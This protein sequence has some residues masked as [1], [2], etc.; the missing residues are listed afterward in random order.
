[1]AD[2]WENMADI[3][4][5]SVQC[6]G[7]QWS[8]SST[9]PCRR[10]RSGV[11]SVSRHVVKGPRSSEWYYYDSLVCP[12]PSSSAIRLKKAL[13]GIW[14]RRRRPPPPLSPQLRPPPQP[15]PRRL[16]LRLFTRSGISKK[17]P[18]HAE[19]LVDPNWL[20]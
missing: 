20:E 9:L 5:V 2:I 6:G 1:M 13:L 14:H 15:R 7:P 12:S 19:G 4:Q 3:Y 10:V 16:R 17:S 11:A 8:S 18:H